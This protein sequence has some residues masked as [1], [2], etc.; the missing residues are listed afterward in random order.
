MPVLTTG[1]IPIQNGDDPSASQATGQ[2]DLAVLASEYYG[3]NIRQGQ[4]FKV[5]AVSMS[6]VPADNVTS[7]GIDIGISAVT[8]LSHIPTT[9][10][11]RKAWNN[12]FTQWRAQKNLAGKVGRQVRYDDMEFAWNIGTQVS[13]RTSTIRAHGINDS[14]DEKLVL[15]GDSTVAS[16]LSL[17]DYYNSSNPSAMPSFDS[18]TSTAVKQPKFGSTMFPD[19]QKL[20]ISGFNS[21]QVDYETIGNEQDGAVAS[22]GF[23]ELITPHSVL[24]GVYHYDVKVM[25]DDTATQIEEDFEIVFSFH[26][27]SF[28]PLVF[29]PKARKKKGYSRKWSRRKG[30]RRSR[31]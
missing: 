7:A 13:G 15:V 19:V 25:P 17:Q 12:I 24:C 8:A 11:S 22:D 29:R 23:I 5:K 2:I 9:S 3:K 27:Q 16:H 20:Y 1:R 21:A 28:K 31:R 10:H 6:L 4:T 30:M 18:F 26:V 14:N